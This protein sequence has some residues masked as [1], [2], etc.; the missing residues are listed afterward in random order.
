MEAA[1][2]R[3][4]AMWAKLKASDYP[5]GTIVF[6]SEETAAVIHPPQ[7][8]QGRL[9]SCGRH[10]DTAVLREQLDSESAHAYGIIVVDGSDACIGTAKGLGMVSRSRCSTKVIANIS[11][12]AAAKTRRGG[13]SALRYARNREIADLTFLRKVAE[14][15]GTVLAD[16]RGIVLAGKAD[17]K[18]RLVPELPELLRKRVIC[19]LDLPCNAGV[20]GLR[21]AAARAAS[22]ADSDQGREGREALNCFMERVAKPDD[23]S[24]V[25]CCY[26]RE[27]T[28]A[29]LKMGAVDILLVS[30]SSENVDE[31]KH[32]AISHGTPIFEVED[33]SVQG[34]QFCSSFVMGGCLRWPIDPELFHQEEQG[35]GQRGDDGNITAG[36][37]HGTPLCEAYKEV[38][39]DIDLAT[40][41]ERAPLEERCLLDQEQYH[42]ASKPRLELLQWL[43]DSLTAALEDS[44]AAE[45]L[46]ACADVVLGE[47]FPFEEEALNETLAM[48]TGEGVPRHIV[49]GLSRRAM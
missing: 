27:E 46:V 15:A 37:S 29:A 35:D 43:K 49:E 20:D 18:Q 7:A 22:A 45:A 10:F 32:L 17:A 34:S 41:A 4:A 8:L 16:V 40:L 11:S 28:V 2:R 48:L 23:V 44:F 3:A 42:D 12:T 9:Y 30:A 21:L 24:G 19:I 38:E 1:L 14:R 47:K 25:T 26:G 13:Q 31:L 36:G 33:S 6:C 5:N 39:A